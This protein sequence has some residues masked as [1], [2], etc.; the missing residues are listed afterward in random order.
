M[1]TLILIPFTI[2]SENILILTFWLIL[3]SFNSFTIRLFSRYCSFLINTDWFSGYS[4]QY[5]K[6]LLLRLLWKKTFFRTSAVVKNIFHSLW[7]AI[8][9]WKNKNLIKNSGH[10]LKM[11]MSSEQ[12][13]LHQ[14]LLNKAS[15]WLF[16]TYIRVFKWKW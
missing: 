10:N 1:N 3:V 5:F 13:Y 7:R 14:I 6:R 9:W 16:Q 12:D 8:I 15:L 11:L 4:V 2:L